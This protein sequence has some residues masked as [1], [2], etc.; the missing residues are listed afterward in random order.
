MP[1]T[2]NEITPI[3]LCIATADLF[4]TKR[5]RA[6]FAD[7]MILRVRDK[8]MERE[9]IPVKRELNSPT[10][11]KKFLDGHKIAIINNIDKILALLENRYAHIDL[12]RVQ[13]ISLA[14][15]ELMAKVLIADN[16]DSIGALESTF[17]N[18]IMLPTYSL[19]V[20]SMK[21]VGVTVV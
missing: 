6:N 16:F 7:N 9:L 10:A 3:A 2:M 12:K 8:S 11:Q 4:D 5:F 15:K 14:G 19:F 20:E 13:E 21:R 18:K 17:R 1:I